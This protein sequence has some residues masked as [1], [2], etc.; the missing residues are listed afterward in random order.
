LLL[1]HFLTLGFDSLFE[2]WHN[3]FVD[4]LDECLLVR[5]AALTQRFQEK[6]IIVVG[7]GDAFPLHSA[8][9]VLFSWL[10]NLDFC[11]GVVLLLFLSFAVFSGVVELDAFASTRAA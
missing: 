10:I 6:V 3:L 9:T 7:D 11:L 8:E 2:D 5:V 4:A 1:E